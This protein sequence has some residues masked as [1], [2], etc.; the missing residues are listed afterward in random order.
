M[1]FI[2]YVFKYFQKAEE[3]K[4]GDNDDVEN[5]KGGLLQ[6]KLF[7]FGI[8]S[9]NLVVYLHIAGREDHKISVGDMDISER[10]ITIL[11]GLTLLVELL[12]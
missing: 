12:F 1:I 4:F 7:F 3:V 6:R 2:T 11:I 8:I 10:K 9:Q 5:K